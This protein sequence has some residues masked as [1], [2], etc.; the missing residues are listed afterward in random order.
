MLDHTEPPIT[1][2]H[3]NR[4]AL[5]LVLALLLVVAVAAVEITSFVRLV[6]VTAV[7]PLTPDQQLA[8]AQSAIGFPIQQ[9]AWLPDWATLE[10]VT[11]HTRCAS[12]AGVNMVMLRYASTSPGGD[13]A[14]DESDG[15]VTFQTD[16]EDAN[17]H[18][19]PMHDAVSDIT[20]NGIPV[21]VDELTGTMANG[22]IREVA[23]SWA[24]DNIY[25]RLTSRDAPG[26]VADLDMLQ[27]IVAS[28]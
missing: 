7:A 19:Q 25:Y 18:V 14:I 16:Y 23:L 6:S 20:L 27:R 12:C 13:I 26:Y 21:H 22:P 3:K 15:L 17:G 8:Q 9:P 10:S 4:R 28:I 11:Y 2:D 1:T 24:H 5:L